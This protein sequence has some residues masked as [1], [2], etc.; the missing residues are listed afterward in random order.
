MPVST[1][2]SRCSV[3][4]LLKRLRHVSR[5]RGF[6]WSTTRAALPTPRAPLQRHHAEAP[7]LGPTWRT[8]PNRS[9]CPQ[10]C[11][12]RARGIV[13]PRTV[14]LATPVVVLPGASIPLGL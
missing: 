10:P 4:T 6:T 7:T 5:T 11:A 2:Y 8:P 13:I 9:P 3:G 14:P 12:Y 1:R